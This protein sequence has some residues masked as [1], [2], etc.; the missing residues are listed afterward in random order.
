MVEQTKNNTIFIFCFV[1]SI[2]NNIP[3]L[4]PIGNTV[5]SGNKAANITHIESCF[6][7]LRIFGG[8]TE[9]IL[10]NWK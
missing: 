3:C 6:S 8:F 5:I 1:T 9:G 2:K 7:F 4:K 10:R